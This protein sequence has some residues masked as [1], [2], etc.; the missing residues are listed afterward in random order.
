MG[1]PAHS[2]TSLLEFISHNHHSL[3]P[4]AEHLL[5]RIHW[6]QLETPASLRRP[7]CN[8][9][10]GGGAPEP[11]GRQSSPSQ[12]RSQHALKPGLQGAGPAALTGIQAGLATQPGLL[13]RGLGLPD[14]GR[15][16]G[17]A[18][19]QSPSRRRSRALRLLDAAGLRSGRCRR[20]L[21][22][23]QGKALS[24][25]GGARRACAHEG[26][27]GSRD[28]GERGSR[29][30]GPRRPSP[31]SH[32]TPPQ[33]PAAPGAWFQGPGL[34]RGRD[35]GLER[36]W[37]D[38]GGW[39]G[40]CDQARRQTG[41]QEAG[42]WAGPPGPH[43]GP[44][45]RGALTGQQGQDGPRHSACTRSA[46]LLPVLPERGKAT[47]RGPEDP[48]EPLLP[49]PLVT[50]RATSRAG[51]RGPPARPPCVTERESGAQE[52]AP[53]PQSA[54]AP[55]PGP[56]PPPLC[57]P[58]LGGPLTQHAATTAASLPQPPR[59]TLEEALAARQPDLPHL[60]AG[61]RRR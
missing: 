56:A 44:P 19:E 11:G 22:A 18:P 30:E 52:T 60:T 38:Q 17:R 40:R 53:T 55:S 26:G 25:A 20:R 36:V 5:S 1:T 45:P 4:V 59:R 14:A 2:E 34:R 24:T 32:L 12:S 27:A 7:E 35:G 51:P 39:P 48:R 41:S 50:P 21:A 46:H 29:R 23:L 31:S 9:L 8:R 15:P 57:R 6:P 47:L 54:S 42:G 28:S 33:N 16:F 13:L 58:P 10:V 37:G 3:A 49:G 43:R 61:W